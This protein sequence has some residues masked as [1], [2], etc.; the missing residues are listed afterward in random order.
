MARNPSP[1][2]P[3]HGISSPAERADLLCRVEALISVLNVAYGKVL[4]SLEQPGDDMARLRAVRSS[5]ERT[6]EVL[7]RARRALRPGNL[8]D[9]ELERLCQRLLEDAA[10]AMEP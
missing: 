6:L 5:L 9:E 3:Q 2:A 4:R 7:E 1:L 10:G 8:Q